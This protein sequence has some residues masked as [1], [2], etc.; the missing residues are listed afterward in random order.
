[1]HFKEATLDDQH[2]LTEIMTEAFNF[3]T[4]LHRQ[5]TQEDGPPGYNDG[6]LARRFLSDSR[7]KTYVLLVD[8]RSI[9]FVNYRMNQVPEP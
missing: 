9:G 6:T 4:A 5:D 1:M 8:G 7:M 3:D 2:L